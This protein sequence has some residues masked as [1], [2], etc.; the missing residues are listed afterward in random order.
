[1]KIEIY[2]DGA[3]SGNPGPMGI[4]AVIVN[5]I[6]KE[7]ISKN[8]GH[9]TNNRAETL[10]VIE[11]LKSLPDIKNTEVTL[12]T[13]SQLIV[14]QL[15]KNWRVNKNADIVNEMKE[16]TNQCKSFTCIKVRGHADNVYNNEADSLA[17]K[18]VQYK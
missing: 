6:H 5:G 11:A 8:M 12:H 16:L 18:A 4:G 17:V 7:S 13:D 10:A 3:C 2:T 15:T 9:G 14:G 1:M